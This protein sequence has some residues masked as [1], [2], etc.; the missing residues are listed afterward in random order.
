[1]SG[2]RWHQ[3]AAY[4]APLPRQESLLS[5]DDMVARIE[6]ARLEEAPEVCPTCESRINLT[7]SRVC[8]ACHVRKPLA[9]FARNRG[10]TLGREHQCKACKRIAAKPTDAARY[11][12]RKREQFR[13][14]LEAAS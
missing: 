10:A 3:A 11:R 1:M 12:N 6:A 14:V 13:A 2:R 8:Y 4:T 5:Q 9:A 7:Q